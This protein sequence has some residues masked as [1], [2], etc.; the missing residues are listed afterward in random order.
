MYRKEEF[1]VDMLN[2][3]S[4][5]QK[6]GQMI[7]IDY[8]ETTEMT[9]DLEEILTKYNPGGFILFRGN[10]ESN[11]DSRDQIKANYR[12]VQ[13]FLK[14]IKSATKIKGIMSVD[15][16]GGRVQRL[17]ERV[18]FDQYPPMGEIGA[19][20][21]LDLAFALGVKKGGELRE[22]GIDM[23]MAPVLDIFSN[24]RNTA[25]GDRAFGKTPESVTKMALS[26]ADGLKKEGIIPVGKHFPGHGGTLKDSHA[27]LPFV[28]KSLE[29]LKE[30]ELKPFEKAVEEKLPGIMVGHLAVPKVTDNNIPASLS[31]KMINGI[32]RTDMGY[33]GLIMTDSVKMKAL[34][35]KTV[36][37]TIEFPDKNPP[38]TDQDIYLR[39][40]QAG[41]DFILMPQDINEAFDTIYRKVEEGIIT[42][43]R[44]D[45]SLYRILSTKL[46]FGL[47]NNEYYNYLASHP[48]GPRR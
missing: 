26:Y 3:M 22:I 21:D 35:D 44:I 36:T 40:V 47:L 30:F 20:E 4:L 43:D 23:D 8:R 41:N 17:G 29:E 31:E 7:M 10:V 5:Q 37:N 6:I 38:L 13:E 42:E 46:E 25:I 28:D 12:K 15:Q 2:N 9:T 14:D 32:L 27:S 18:G 45:A 11:I 19:T 33:D 16:E 39:C 1:L 48:K 24:P 34:K